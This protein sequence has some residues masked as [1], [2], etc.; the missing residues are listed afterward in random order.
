MRSK[1]GQLLINRVIVQVPKVTEIALYNVFAT[2]AAASYVDGRVFM[3]IPDDDNGD[4]L[5]RMVAKGDDLTQPRNIDFSVLFADQSSAE[6]FAEHFRSLGYKVSL[7]G[8]Y[9]KPDFSWDV[10]VVRHM[11]AT[12]EGIADFENFLQSVADR[13]GGRNDGWGCFSGPS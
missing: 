11:P 10:T 12:H 1:V 9:P 5:R 7:K 13:W 6:K 4:V 2:N 3:F 8:D